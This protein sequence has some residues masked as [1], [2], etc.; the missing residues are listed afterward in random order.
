MHNIELLTNALSYIEQNLECNLRTEEIAGACY[1]SKSTLEKLFRCVNNISVH[2]YIIRRRMTKAAKML[3]SHPERPILEI[4]LEY[5]YSTHESFTRSFKQIWNC[6]PSEFRQKKRFSELFPRYLPPRQKGDEYMKTCKNVD[7]SELYD[8]FTERKN[9]Y[10]VCCDIKHMVPINEI[11]HA[12]G[13]LAILESMKRMEEAAGPEDVVFRIG[14]D[15]F[16]LLTASEDIKYAELLAEQI[17]KRN[18]ETFSYEGKDIPLELYAGIMKMEG[19][20][21]NYEELY[22]EL[23]QTIKGSKVLPP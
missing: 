15:E 14:G 9:C 7:I 10:F 16:A 1:C 19:P 4:A 6:K 12:A 17:Q 22:T 8:F 20:V 21:V 18:G 3:V 13:D 11:A 5:G 2:D 23:H